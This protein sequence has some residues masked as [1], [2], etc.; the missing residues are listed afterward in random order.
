MISGQLAVAAA[1]LLLAGCVPDHFEY[2]AP[3]APAGTL[4]SFHGE[5]NDVKDV[6]YFTAPGIDWVKLSV[7]ATPASGLNISIAR[8]WRLAFDHSDDA[9][10]ERNMRRPIPVRF[11]LDHFMIFTAVSQQAVKLQL[12]GGDSTTFVIQDQGYEQFVTSPLLSG[13]HFTVQIPRVSIDGVEINVPE[14]SFTKTSTVAMT[15]INC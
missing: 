7:H 9:E 14:I 2:Y 11:A 6:M 12:P 3:Q 13:D 4:E 15:G 1:A 10:L 8:N 5:C